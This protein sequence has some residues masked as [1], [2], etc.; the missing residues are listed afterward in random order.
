M[1]NN[2]LLKSMYFQNSIGNEEL[3]EIIVN[4]KFIVQKEWF[5]YCKPIKLIINKQ[6]NTPGKLMLLVNSSMCFDLLDKKQYII[7][8]VNIY[9]NKIIINEII[10]NSDYNFSA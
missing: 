7:D 1:N 5:E 2:S 9:F 6:I 10:L 8:C 3:I 4:W